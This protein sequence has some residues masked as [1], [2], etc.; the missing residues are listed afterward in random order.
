MSLF[1]IGLLKAIPSN[2]NG[3]DFQRLELL[4]ACLESVRKFFEIF[5]ETSPA[6]YWNL[7]IIHFSRFACALS[8]LQRLSTFEDPTW[9]LQYVAAKVNFSGIVD[10]ICNHMDDALRYGG[11]ELSNSSE[12]VTIFTRITP[13]LRM[14][15]VIYESRMSS[16]QSATGRIGDLSGA[17]TINIENMVESW[18]QDLFDIVDGN[19]WGL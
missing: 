4:Y 18:E 7:T 9:D 19:W 6:S 2:V 12:C 10:Q 3:P 5:L 15:N 8:L 16:M 1:E 13:K 14:L 17:D 11:S